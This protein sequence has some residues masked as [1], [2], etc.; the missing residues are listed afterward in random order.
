MVLYADA[1]DGHVIATKTS[2]LI[3]DELGS[4]LIGNKQE[5]MIVNNKIVKL[6]RT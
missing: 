5:P 6:V 3:G 4:Y 2:M 1:H